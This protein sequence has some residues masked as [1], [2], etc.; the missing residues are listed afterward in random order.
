MQET[1]VGI[2][3]D[4]EFVLCVVRRQGEV[5]G[6]V[7]ERQLEMVREREAITAALRAEL[8]AETELLATVVDRLGTSEAKIDAYG[9]GLVALAPINVVLVVAVLRNWWVSARRRRQEWKWKSD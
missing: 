4:T 1:C 8:T 2:A 6:R 3:N 5:I 9:Q 7:A